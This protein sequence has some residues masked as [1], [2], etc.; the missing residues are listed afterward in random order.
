MEKKNIQNIKME[1]IKQYITW[2]GKQDPGQKKSCSLGLVLLVYSSWLYI[3]E[4][5]SDSHMAIY[6]TIK[7]MIGINKMSSP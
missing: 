3:P 2:P 6:H 5:T 7:S 4:G 1:Y